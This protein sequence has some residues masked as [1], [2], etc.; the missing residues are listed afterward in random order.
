MYEC[1]Y[2]CMYTS[3]PTSN[4]KQ[5]TLLTKLT[6]TLVLAFCLCNPYLILLYIVDLVFQWTLWIVLLCSLLSIVRYQPSVTA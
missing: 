2:V 3:L 6:Q 1:M 5:A 4:K